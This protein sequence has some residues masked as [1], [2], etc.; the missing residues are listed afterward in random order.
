M[1]EHLDLLQDLL[2]VGSPQGFVE[3]CRDLRDSML[4]YDREVLIGA[5]TGVVEGLAFSVLLD[6]AIGQPE[7]FPLTTE[8]VRDFIRSLPDNLDLR[9]YPMDVQSLAE[10]FLETG[11]RSLYEAFPAWVATLHV[12]QSGEFSEQDDID[13]LL[14]EARHQAELGNESQALAKIG[15]VGAL[16]LLGR[17]IRPAWGRIAGPLESWL[18]GLYTAVEAVANHER[19]TYPLRPIVEERLRRS[20]R[21][22]LRDLSLRR[23]YEEPASDVWRELDDVD[24]FYTEVISGRDRLSESAY[25]V[26]Q[27]EGP[28]LLPVLLTILGARELRD[29]EQGREHLAPVRA[30]EA[31]VALNAAEAVPMLLRIVAEVDPQDALFAAAQT[32]LVKLGSAAA[33]QVLSF[34]SGEADAET[35][36]Y[37]SEV[38]SRMEKDERVFRFLTSLFRKT[39]WWEGKGSLV[40]A[41]ADYGDTRALPLLRD[42]L[43]NLDQRDSRQSELLREAIGNLSRRAERPKLS[44]RGRRLRRQ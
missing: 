20:A 43:R 28:I 18:H 13:R 7:S 19:L 3:T 37:L 15:R 10:R 29:D 42:A 14:A 24:R 9:E 27:A 1:A 25:A 5:Y 31:L 30:L 38:L 6:A 39:S 44:P 11:G 22:V 35:A 36:I 41:L 17:R 33:P 12:Y 2:E 40:R 32:A 8:R 23:R 26:V 16:A 4:F 21:G 34:A